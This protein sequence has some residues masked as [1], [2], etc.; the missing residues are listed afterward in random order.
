M[1][2]CIKI[3]FYIAILLLDNVSMNSRNMFIICEYLNNM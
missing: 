2:L 1:L 3:T